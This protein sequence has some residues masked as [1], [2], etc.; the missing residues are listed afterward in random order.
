M[1][2]EAA[3]AAQPLASSRMGWVAAT[4]TWDAASSHMVMEVVSAMRGGA[5]PQ[6]VMEAVY[7][8]DDAS[9]KAVMES[10]HRT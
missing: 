8:S 3:N 6:T 2:V 10:W 5:S 1:V 7:D 4:A 9:S